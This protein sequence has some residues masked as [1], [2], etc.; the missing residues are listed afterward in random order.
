MEPEPKS[1]E[2]KLISCKDIKTFNFFQKLT[3][4]ALVFIESEDPRRNLTEEQKQKQRT[5]THIEND[6]DRTNPEWNHEARFDLGWLTKRDFA[7]VFLHFEFRHDGVI[8]GDKL[9]G[10]CRVPLV[11]LIRGGDGV[12]RFVNYEVR[13]GEG[14]PNGI[15]NFSY[16]LN[17]IGNGT[18]LNNILEGRI[19]GYPVLPPQDCVPI[20]NMSSQVQYPT[21][22]IENPCCYP[23]VGSAVYCPIVEPPPP[24]PPV[25]SPTC[26]EC[27]YY[28]PPL[29]S[30]SQ[31]MAYPY[32]PPPPPVEQSY[33]PFGPSVHPWPS[34]P[35]FEGR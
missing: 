32:P 15:F 23:P 1:I 14:K 28:Y 27:Y 11:D 17:G 19:S 29:P 7:D 9:I 6:G 26:G 2:V 16:K 13:S 34:D 30:P 24:P 3:L 18:H 22:G 21:L 5:Q 20:P 35:Y 8:L 33:P 12:A 4:Y 10:E 31:P 25:L